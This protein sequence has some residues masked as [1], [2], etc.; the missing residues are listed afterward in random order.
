MVR[1]RVHRQLVKCPAPGCANSRSFAR[2]QIAEGRVFCSQTCY[3]AV[4][5]DGELVKCP[6]A[7]CTNSRW[8]SRS[9]IAEGRVYCSATCYHAAQ[10][11]GIIKTRLNVKQQL[12]ECAAE[13]CTNTVRR[14]PSQRR[15]TTYC[16]PECSAVSRRKPVTF[17]CERCGRSTEFPTTSGQQ[18]RKRRYCSP[19]CRK[20]V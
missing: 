7:G 10:R 20:S 5:R 1:A 19:A 12:V 4:R 13:G 18:L 16:S 3:L 8:M 11:A 2:W 14:W 17:T 15:Q 6:A 9:R